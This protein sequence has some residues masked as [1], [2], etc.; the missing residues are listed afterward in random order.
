VRRAE[1]ISREDPGLG[2]RLPIVH[3][4]RLR[5]WVAL[6]VT[7]AT[8]AFVA[9]AA[10]IPIEP[11]IALPVSGLPANVSLTAGILFWLLFGLLGGLRA[12]VRP[13]GAVLTFS[14]PFIVAGTLLGGPLAGGLMGLVSE[15][16]IR[17][18]RTQ[19]WYG[20]LANH[21]VSVL[22]AIGAA[23]VGGPARELLEWLLPG[24]E[25]AAFFVGAMV[26]ALV[27]EAINVILVVPTL[28][29][30]HGLT[31]AESSRSKDIAFRWTAVAEAILAWN[32]A[33]SYL[34]IGW[35]APIVCIGLVLIIWSAYDRSEAL[36]RDPKTG[37]LNDAG[38]LPRIDAAIAAAQA[39]RRSSVLLALD[40]DRFWEVN[41]RFGYEAGDEVL[42]Q[43]ARRLLAA[44]RATDSIGRRNAAG[45]EFAILLDG[46]AGL[47]AGTLVARRILD[48]IREPIRLR[49]V[50]ATVKIDASIGVLVLDRVS[51]A[52]A[53]AHANARMQAAKALGAGIVD[54]DVARDAGLD[55]AERARM[56]S[57]AALR[58]DQATALDAGGY[59]DPNSARRP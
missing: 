35:W 20:I 38:L 9:V 34:V 28:S 51:A 42:I 6:Q 57:K 1:V 39:G 31:L 50:E 41:E 18:V 59:H 2:V 49:R 7:V 8:V 27:F 19:P 53:V 32:M 26:T 54:H 46:V 44:V 13:G 11:E 25:P 33:A 29:L 16:E 24:Q 12:R 14:M 58:G 37:L 45:D 40:L 23:L 52:E 47:E 30:R 55:A 48:A 43:T 36:Q 22:A 56:A 15:L 4:V 3:S 21:A 5:A 17:E 10:T